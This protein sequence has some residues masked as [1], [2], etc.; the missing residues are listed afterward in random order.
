MSVRLDTSA[1][2]V[3]ERTLNTRSIEQWIVEY[4]ITTL[5]LERT[6]ITEADRLAELGVDSIEAVALAQAL[7]TW[8]DQPVAETIA[9]EH[10][11]ISELARHLSGE[12]TTVVH[13]RTVVDVSRDSVVR[14]EGELAQHP[15]KLYVNPHLARLLEHLGLD[16]QFVRGQGSI[17]YDRAGQRYLD[18]IATYGALP[19]GHNP[20]E[21][22]DALN[23]VRET[24]EPNLAQ[25]SFISAAGALASRLS[26]LAPPGLNYVTF[27]NSGTEAVEAAIKMCRMA[28]GRL[29][30]LSATGSF[31]GKTLGALSATGNPDYQVGAGAPVM[32]FEQFPYGDTRAFEDMLLKRPDHYA[33]CLLEPIQG[34]G[35]IVEP[36]AGY[37]TEMREVCDRHGVL[38]VFDE[39]QTGLGRTGAWFACDHEGV[40]PDVMTLAKALGGGLIPI[41]AV[42]ATRR[43]YTERFALKHSS[44]FAAGGVACRVGLATLDILARD[45]GA[46]IRQVATNGQRLKEALV[47]L[48]GR[49]PHLISEVR[50][51]GFLLGIR[52]AVHHRTWPSSLLA[53]AAHHGNFAPLFAGYL[54]N[55]EKLRVAP[56]LNHSDVIRIE[57]AL[58][59]TWEEC[60]QALASL[61]RAFDAFSSGHAGR[62]LTGIRTGEVLPQEKSQPKRRRTRAHRPASNDGRFAFL[63]HPMDMSSYVDFDS[64]LG[65]L[66]QS[67]LDDACSVFHGLEDV[68]WIGSTRIVSPTGKSAYG[69]FFLV[70]HTAAELTN[71][72]RSEAIA[73]VREATLMAKERGA[74]IVGLGAFT[75]IVTQGGLA[76]IDTDVA[77]TSGNSYTVFSAYEAITLALSERGTLVD[78]CDRESGPTIAIVGAAG[79]I[80][81]VSAVLLAHH[82]DRL[83]LVGNPRRAAEHERIRLVNV[84]ATVCQH[85]TERSSSITQGGPLW[86]HI[87]DAPDLPKPGAPLSDFC[88]FVDRMEQRSEHWQFTQDIASAAREADAILLATSATRTLLEPE[89]IK[90][91]AVICDVSRPRNVSRDISTA[92]PDI[93]LIDGGVIEIPGRPDIGQFGMERGHVYACMAE[94]MLLALEQHYEHHSLGPDIKLADVERLQSLATINEFRVVAV[95]NI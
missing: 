28:T 94:T 11:T 61:E 43:A 10:P 65:S 6:S 13:K 58:T 18:F 2:P 22:W 12:R 36:P 45:D 59:T 95:N 41:G 29:G 25:P 79:A 74:Q 14:Q 21:I 60:E 63:L 78:E 5:G 1:P 7:S 91:N 24:E 92:R 46:V 3:S 44:T 32:H 86:R 73:A 89:D 38:L 69:E 35:G 56:T 64:T 62:I 4:L 15:F 37:L 48:A 34:E 9:W 51:Q 26:A 47:Q 80:G 83:I 70:G 42:L 30:I 52:F 82:V 49:Y 54:L 84:A 55:V 53:I 75:S 39:I 40:V 50:G 66:S 31:H 90:A 67:Q 72:P 88:D 19:F 33:A 81:R 71:M 68:N 57:P 85:L 8:L 76:L 87:R 93:L 20:S 27:A 17:L 16:K 77:L 23:R